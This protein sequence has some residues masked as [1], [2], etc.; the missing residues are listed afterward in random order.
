M[1]ILS[2]PL[3]VLP[4]TNAKRTFKPSRYNGAYLLGLNGVVV[5]SHGNTDVDGF[6]FAVRR[7]VRA[8]RKQIPDLISSVEG[9]DE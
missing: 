8:G 9:G 2:L 5:K 1:G 6:Y 3:A 7:L 4:L